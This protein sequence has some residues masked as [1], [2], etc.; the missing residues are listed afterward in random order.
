MV[1]YVS[2]SSCDLAP[3]LLSIY[4]TYATSAKS[5][6][7][8]SQDDSISAPSPPPAF[9]HQVTTS[10]LHTASSSHITSSSVITSSAHITSPLHT[11]SSPHITLSAP[12][13]LS[14]GNSSA[15]HHRESQHCCNYPQKPVTSTQHGITAYMDGNENVDTSFPSSSSFTSPSRFVS[16]TS[17]MEGTVT[18]H[19]PAHPPLLLEQ[20]A[21]KKRPLSVSSTSSSASSTSSLPRHQRKRLAAAAAHHDALL[22]ETEE[23]QRAP[24]N[25]GTQRISQTSQDMDTSSSLS[26]A[27]PS[28]STTNADTSPYGSHT[29]LLSP[30]RSSTNSSNSNISLKFSDFARLD[31]EDKSASVSPSPSPNPSRF[32]LDLTG[33]GS[34]IEK[35][36][37]EIIDTERTYVHDLKDI[38]QVGS[39]YCCIV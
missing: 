7:F 9:K 35:V 31:S 10:S 29:E 24:A 11:T 5:V 21:A 3:Q 12:L 33:S 13:P 1:I 38:I 36:V 6:T 37:T 17:N 15:C 16:T 2:G 34:Y 30:G 26:S 20:D 39:S 28:S 23:Q 25:T 18:S 27:L 19:P 14:T 8:A 32:N 22:L 4:D